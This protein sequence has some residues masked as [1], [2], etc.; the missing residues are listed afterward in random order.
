MR[1]A[2]FGSAAYLK[3]TKPL[4]SGH[5]QCPT[6]PLIGTCARG[7]AAKRM[8]PA[9]KRFKSAAFLAHLASFASRPRSHLPCGRRVE[10]LVIACASHAHCCECAATR[11]VPAGRYLPAICCLHTV[12][13]WLSIYTRVDRERR[14][15]DHWSSDV[16]LVEHIAHEEA[17]T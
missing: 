12:V 10:S 9:T 6:R 7:L 17:E 8:L 14:K 5:P 15:E 16:G 3:P 2:N 13:S 4:A 1:G 11:S